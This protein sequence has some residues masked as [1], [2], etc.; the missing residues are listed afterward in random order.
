MRKT[1]KRVLWLM[2]TEPDVYSF[3]QF[4]KDGTTF[5]EGVRNYQ[6]RNY[7][8]HSMKVGD[9]VFFYH[10]NASPPGIVG[11]AEVV[12]PAKPD[13]SALNPKSLYFDEKSTPEKPRWFAVTLGNPIKAK[14]FLSLDELRQMQLKNSSKSREHSEQ[15][16]SFALLSKGSRLSIVPVPELVS[17][18]ILN[19]LF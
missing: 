18:D 3:Q 9:L 19:E 16:S 10:S 14:N 1:N 4:Q 2:K 5:W 13:S 17:E 15:W 12:E 8:T 6:A 7:M 11:V